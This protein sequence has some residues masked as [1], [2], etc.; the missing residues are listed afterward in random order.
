[1]MNRKWTLLFSAHDGQC[2]AVASELREVSSDS[3]VE[4]E[5]SQG[6]HHKQSAKSVCTSEP[7]KFSR[8]SLGGV[9]NNV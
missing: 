4:R 5:C 9:G 8:D 2:L 1:M 6:T 3:R 7:S